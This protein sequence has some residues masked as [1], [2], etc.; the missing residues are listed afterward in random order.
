MKITLLRFNRKK[1]TN[2]S[3]LKTSKIFQIFSVWL[4]HQYKSSHFTI[5]FYSVQRTRTT[6][7]YERI[8]LLELKLVFTVYNFKPAHE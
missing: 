6:N 3:L 5:S 2:I 4:H 8:F 7:Q 1:K